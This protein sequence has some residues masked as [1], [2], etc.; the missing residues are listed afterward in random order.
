MSQS[1]TFKLDLP[2]NLRYLNL[3]GACI[4]AI[5]ERTEGV[6]DADSL[7]YSIELAVQET[8]TNVVEHAYAGQDGRIQ[9]E[10]TL[11]HAPRRLTVDVRDKGKPFDPG[12]VPPPPLDEVQYR[13]YGLFLMQELM[14]EIDYHSD[15]G[16]NHWHMVKNLG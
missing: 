4:G 12:S 15:A 9:V 10:F 16:G 7:R 8:C 6:H 1:D 13:G 11:S 2:A 5:L 3:V 14:D